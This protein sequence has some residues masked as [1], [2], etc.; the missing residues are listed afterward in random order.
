MISH[1]GGQR[2][3]AR[4]FP[5][6]PIWQPP[7]VLP[8]YRTLACLNTASLPRNAATTTKPRAR[9]RLPRNRCDTKRRLFR[10]PGWI[11]PT[12]SVVPLPAPGS[13]LLLPTLH[14]RARSRDKHAATT[15]RLL[16]FAHLHMAWR[17]R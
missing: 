1:C 10:T 8:L 3:D 17:Q 11:Q 15:A 12:R 4:S 7:P 6:P 14:L 13:W 9:L 16:P 5:Y 2:H